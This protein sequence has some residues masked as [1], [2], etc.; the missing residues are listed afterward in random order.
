MNGFHYSN[1]QIDFFFLDEIFFECM[2]KS[3]NCVTYTVI[4]QVLLKREDGMA[5]MDHHEKN[6]KN[7]L[8]I[9]FN[10]VSVYKD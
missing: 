10:L 4:K 5:M 6:N 7:K 1:F 8:D 2:N 3:D 9:S